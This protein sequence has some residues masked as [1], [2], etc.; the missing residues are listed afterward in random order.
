MSLDR[1][2]VET[3]SAVAQKI[4]EAKREVA[5]AL[6]ETQPLTY[7]KIREMLNDCQEIMAIH[8]D[9]SPFKLIC[10]RLDEINIE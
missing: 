1:K 2:T 7:N 6:S 4:A 10:G 5:N 9:T 3:M 8:C